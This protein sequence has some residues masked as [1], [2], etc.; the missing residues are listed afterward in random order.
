MDDFDDGFEVAEATDDFSD[1]TFMPDDFVRDT[2]PEVVEAE[3][4]EFQEWYQEQ[5]GDYYD[6]DVEG[7]LTDD[8]W[9][10]HKEYQLSSGGGHRTLKQAAEKVIKDIAF[11]KAFL[12][13]FDGDGGW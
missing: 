4:A 5:T 12:E 10:A 6:P 13:G 7:N 9:N 1:D 11:D 3:V 2:S 8:F